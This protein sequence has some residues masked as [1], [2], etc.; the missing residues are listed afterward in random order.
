MLSYITASWAAISSTIAGIF[1]MIYTYLVNKNA[2]LGAKNDS[3][4]KEV[5][6][7]KNETDRIIEVQKKQVEIASSPIPSRDEL[8]NRLRDISTRNEA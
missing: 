5:Q 2:K 6:D 1:F 4:T 7:I 3:L 8:Y